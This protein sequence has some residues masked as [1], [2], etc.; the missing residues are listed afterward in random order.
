[1]D[2]FTEACQILSQHTSTLMDQSD[3]QGMARNMDMNKDGQIDFNEFLEAFRIVDVYGEE[4]QSTENIENLSDIA[5][6]SSEGTARDTQ[7]TWENEL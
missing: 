6:V 1:M 5:S 4:F 3:I 7:E 2:E